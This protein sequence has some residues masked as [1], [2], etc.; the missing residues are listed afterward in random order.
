[1]TSG[2]EAEDYCID[3]ISGQKGLNLYEKVLFQIDGMAIYC[4]KTKRHNA[5]FSELLISA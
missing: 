1:M 5:P 3:V 2:L 4:G